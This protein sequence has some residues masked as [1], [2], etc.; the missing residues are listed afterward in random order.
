MA[1][2]SSGLPP[3]SF[4]WCS[5]FWSSRGPQ[6]SLLRALWVHCHHPGLGWGVHGVSR[7]DSARG[8]Q[9]A[10]ACFSRH[11]LRTHVQGGRPG[12]KHMKPFLDPCYPLG[13]V[14]TQAP[15]QEQPV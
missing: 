9:G 3:T 4:R 8:S 2:D 11:P 14:R 13:V 12:N 5:L 10:L 6:A 15:P 7:G 1:G